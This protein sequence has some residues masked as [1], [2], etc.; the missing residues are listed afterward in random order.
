MTA[1]ENYRLMVIEKTTQ[2]PEKYK[3]AG[4]TFTSTGLPWMSGED[5]SKACSNSG[6]A[7]L[8]SRRA[9]AGA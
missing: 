6:G 8:R 1:K 4:V 2:G 3:L 7:A 9:A 5:D